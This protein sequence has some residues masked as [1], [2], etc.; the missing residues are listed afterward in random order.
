MCFCW[1]TIQSVH[2][3]YVYIYMVHTHENTDTVYSTLAENW[4]GG[5]NIFYG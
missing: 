3:V 5:L 4:D 1:L 2:T